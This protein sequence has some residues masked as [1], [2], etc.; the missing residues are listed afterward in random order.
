MKYV[1]LLVLT[2]LVTAV[3]GTGIAGAAIDRTPARAAGSPA[4]MIVERDPL[5]GGQFVYV[6][7]HALD[8]DGFCSSIDG[9]VSRHPVL[10]MPVTFT[11]ESGDGIIIDS[12]KGTGVSGRTARDVPTFSTYLNAA[13]ANPVR[14]FPPLVNGIADEC[15]A[16]VKVSQSIPGPLRVLVTV[17][18]DDGTPIGFIAD[19]ART[20]TTTVT[21]A[22]RWSLVTWAGKDGVAPGAAL[23]GPEGSEDIT[24][25][26]T[27][28]YGWDGAA[29]AWRAYFPGS[30]GIPGAND[31]A[32]LK[33]GQAY[34]VAVKGPGAI[35]WG[36][37]TD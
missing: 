17:A 28:I 5:T 14:A 7:F 22:F 2:V 25:A 36:V 26:V 1:K 8:R 35:S 18:G 12:G 13:S 29:Q 16:W 10:D 24:N 19:L 4:Q 21:L 20:T 6:V 15:Q 11:I 9:S 27:A 23:R 3:V 37:E 32:A 33:A 31:L 34:W 30:G